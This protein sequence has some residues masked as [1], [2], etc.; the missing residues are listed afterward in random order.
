[1]QSDLTKIISGPGDRLNEA[2]VGIFPPELSI[3]EFL[4]AQKGGE[5]LKW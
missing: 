4:A 5:I 2:Q 1:M 3:R